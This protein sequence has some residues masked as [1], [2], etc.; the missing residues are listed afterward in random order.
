VLLSLFNFS[1][2]AQIS[3]SRIKIVKPTIEQEATSIWRTIN[4]ITFFENQ[5][6]TI[7][8]PKDS[9]IDRLIV[10]SK[11]GKFGNE[12]LPVIYDFVENKIYDQN[13][14]DKAIQKLTDHTRLIDSLVDKISATSKDWDWKFK[15]FDEYK[16]VFT[17]YGTGG[18]YDPDEGLITLLTNKEGNF[19]NYENPANTVIHEI[20]H[21]GIEHS[22]I[23]KYN[24]THPLKERIADNFVHLNYGESLPNYKV[25][26]M[27]DERLDA[28][29][30]DKDDFKDLE[31]VIEKILNDN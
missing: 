13:D 20:V 3:A 7:N 24:V 25:Q 28:Y 1:C 2:K 11:E 9:L 23:R 29:I 30:K 8:L 26:Q 17:L 12:D 5:G 18:S 27:G 10:K 14:Y 6:Y 16:I 4:D 31:T 21:I 22:I 19:M 15:L